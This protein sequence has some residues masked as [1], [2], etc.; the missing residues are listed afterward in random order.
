MRYME[1]KNGS[2][3]SNPVYDWGLILWLPLLFVFVVI[4]TGG[5]NDWVPL[6]PREWGGE[7]FVGF[8]TA[9]ALIVYALG[10]WYARN[11]Q[12]VNPPASNLDS[13]SESN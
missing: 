11:C 6:I 1:L 12:P 2:P 9:Y 8:N 4:S 13:P 3:L 10:R 7:A 5:L